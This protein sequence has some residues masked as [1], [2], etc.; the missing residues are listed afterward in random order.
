MLKAII[1]ASVIM[2][3]TAKGIHRHN[4]KSSFQCFWP[5]K[6]VL[7]IPKYPLLGELTKPRVSTEQKAG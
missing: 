3:S 4:K 5:A 1:Q 2:L 6:S 7:I